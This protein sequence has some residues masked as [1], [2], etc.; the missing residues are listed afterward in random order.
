MAS[1]I[2]VG[3]QPIHLSGKHYVMGV[4][5]TKKP[6]SGKKIEMELFDLHSFLASCYNF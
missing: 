5:V 4:S 2:V 1:Q 3:K 6:Q